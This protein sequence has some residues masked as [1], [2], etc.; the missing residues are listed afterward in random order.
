M[1]SYVRAGLVLLTLIVYAQVV[2]F[3]FVFIDDPSYIVNNAQVLNG[4][5]PEGIAWAFETGQEANW[6]PL[7]WI[8]LMLDATLF[9]KWPG[10]YH[11]TNL[12]LHAGSV[13]LLFNALERMTGS[14]WPSAFTAAMFAIH[15]QHVES[16]AWVTERKD[17]LSVFFGML[18]LWAYARYVRR[19]SDRRYLLIAIAFI[20]SLLAKQTLVTFPFLLLVLDFWPLQ[21]FQK[22]GGPLPAPEEPPRASRQ[23]I[24]DLIIEKLPLLFLSLVFCII[25]VRAQGQVG[26]IA[27]LKYYPLSD[28]IVNAI[29][30]Y[31]MYIAQACWPFDLVIFYSRPQGGYSAAVVVGSAAILLTLTVIAVATHRSR[32]YLL[33]GWLWYLGTLAPVIGIVQVGDQARADRYTY[34]PTIGLSIMAA[35]LIADIVARTPSFRPAA[36]FLGGA[37]VAAAAVLCFFQAQHWRNGDALFDHGYAVDPHNYFLVHAKGTI[38]ARNNKPEDAIRLFSEAIELNPRY[39]RAL[40][41]RGTTLAVL[42]RYD[43]ALA[44]IDEALKLNPNLV[45]AYTVRA[46]VYG[47]QRK[48]DESAEALK[49]AV[50][51]QPTLPELHAD[52]ART[53]ERAG[54]YDDALAAYKRMLEVKSDYLVGKLFLARLLC[55]LGKWQELAQLAAEGSRAAPENGEFRALL[56]RAKV[57]LGQV[58]PGLADIEQ[59]LRAEPRSGRAWQVAAATQFRLGNLDDAL[60]GYARASEFEPYDPVIRREYGD[61]LFEKK[62]I[63]KATAE[64]KKAVEIDPLDPVP[65]GALATLL[66][67]QGKTDQAMKEYAETLRLNPNV[68]N[69]ANDYAWL[70]ATQPDSKRRDANEALKWAEK[71]CAL[72]KKED[73]SHLDTLAAAQAEAGRWD[74]AV[75]TATQSITLYQKKGKKKEADDVAARLALYQQK[76]PYREKT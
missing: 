12:L 8:S 33:A 39:Y 22:N 53:L 27:P 18:A 55:R 14:L 9:G 60:V 67:I 29:V 76:K 6:H 3:D 71:A 72:S 57:E 37:S 2:R 17:T 36:V 62:E 48:F 45:P 46:Q 24:N 59:G 23:S 74:D 75:K 7:T 40:L 63:L 41:D 52:L 44:D 49:S 35:W 54:R 31:V 68:A 43:E 61:L 13:L 21:R 51:K 25:V 34:F 69:L 64:F 15:P 70:L 32:P 19:P 56:G 16:V 4:L 5:T 58:K 30:S 38:Q 20:L 11:L 10:G 42:K 50:E 73:P 28:R 65:R 66:Q 26:A 47:A 1:R